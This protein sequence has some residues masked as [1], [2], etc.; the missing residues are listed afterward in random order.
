MA[1]KYIPL[2]FSLF[3][4]SF[5]S[6]QDAYSYYLVYLKDKPLESYTL[7]KPLDFLSQEAISR[8]TKRKSEITLADIP[9]SQQYLSQLNDIKGVFI[10]NKSKWLNAVEI[11]T[12]GDAAIIDQLKTLACVARIEFLG[13]IKERAKP[14]IE[15]LKDEDYLNAKKLIQKKKDSGAWMSTDAAY[16][17]SLTQI[18]QIGINGLHTFS[19]AKDMHIAVFDAGFYNAYKVKGMEDLAMPDV[20][21]RDY[22]DYDNSVW[23][24]DRHGANVLSFMKTW[25][26]GTYIGSAP[27][28][29]YTLVR[30]ENPTS[31]YPTEEVNWLFAAE[32]ADS[33]GVDMIVSSLGYHTFDD[34]S[35]SHTHKQLDGKTS[36]IAQAANMAYARGILIVTSAGNEG[37]KKWHKIGTPSD[38]AGVLGIGACDDHGFHANFS[39]VGPSADGRV[40]PD[41]LAMGLKAIVASP[42]GI[43]GGNGTSYATPIFG[44]AMACLINAFPEKSFDELKQALLLSATHK[45][46][47][48]SAYGYGLPDFTLAMHILGYFNSTDTIADFFYVKSNPVFFQDLG[49]YFR[50]KDAQTIKISIKGKRKKNMRSLAHETYKLKAGEWLHEDILFKLYS[51]E[52]KKKKKYKLQEL[53]LLIETSGG[54][55]QKTIRLSY[56]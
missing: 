3:I 48:D 1:F 55:I 9:V 34:S 27:F 15:P 25:H 7:D 4:S 20:I 56:D 11:R 19:M 30:T 40:K 43:Y 35:L 21:I 32:F 46:K 49:I 16:G 10:I 26:P 41:Y 29:R 44:G 23:E 24:D 42:A 8:R 6:A 54:T 50:S 12:G 22:V 31:E 53:V 17:R 38:A 18:A 5:C 14:E 45:S 52:K 33:L 39:S 36:I 37:G 47:P 51:K 28:A 13:H 2:F